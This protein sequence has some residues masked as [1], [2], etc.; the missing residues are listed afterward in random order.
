MPHP[1]VERTSSTSRGYCN[2]KN[3]V[4]GTTASKITG[5]AIQCISSRI[6]SESAALNATIVAAIETNNEISP[7]VNLFGK[8]YKKSSS[9]KRELRTD[10]NTSTEVVEENNATASDITNRIKTASRKKSGFPWPSF[11]PGA[12]KMAANAMVT[13]R[14]ATTVADDAV[15]IIHCCASLRSSLCSSLNTILGVWFSLFKASLCE[16]FTSFSTS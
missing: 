2:N 5:A 7:S 11:P 3:N 12:V 15:L 8:A 16:G 14:A 6:T 9:A 4:T 10:K 1:Y 13:I